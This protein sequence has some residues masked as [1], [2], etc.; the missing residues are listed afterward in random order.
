MEHKTI[1]LNGVKIHYVQAG[2]GPVVLLLHGLGSSLDTWRR[3]LEPLANAGFTV[4]APTCPATVTLKSQMI[5]TMDP[6][7]P[8]ISPDS[9]SAPW[10]GE[11]FVGG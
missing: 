9:F 7:T 2:Q 11:S 4:R 8:S 10:G 5:W 3:N 6:A 1:A